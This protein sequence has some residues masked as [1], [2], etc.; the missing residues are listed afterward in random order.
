MDKC[1]EAASQQDGSG[2]GAHRAESWAPSES[3]HSIFGTE[4]PVSNS[5]SLPSRPASRVQSSGS[6]HPSALPPAPASAIPRPVVRGGGKIDM[7]TGRAKMQ[8]QLRK[9]IQQSMSGTSPSI[10]EPNWKN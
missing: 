1:T 10:F 4:E 3:L 7:A 2:D 9:A 5:V 8:D 6:Y